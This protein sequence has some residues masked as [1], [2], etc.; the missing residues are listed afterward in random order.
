[1]TGTARIGTDDCPHVAD[2][3]NYALGHCL[4]DERRQVEAHLQKGEC[5]G[6]QGWVDRATR[7]RAEP[8]PDV[9]AGDLSLALRGVAAAPATTSDP[10]PIPSSSQWQR[11]VFL[12]L[13]DR[14]QRLED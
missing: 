3:I 11:R 10:T 4:N 12:D 9:S 14:L 8:G 5:S 6:C 1:A 13:E 2:L 7:L